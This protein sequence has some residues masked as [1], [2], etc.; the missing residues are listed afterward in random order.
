MLP[1][2]RV[3][4]LPWLLPLD[5]LALSPPPPPSL[6]YSL[7]PPYPFT[8][9]LNRFT[10]RKQNPLLGA[11]ALQD[12]FPAAS[13]LLLTATQQEQVIRKHRQAPQL[14]GS[15]GLLFSVP[16]AE[17]LRAGGGTARE[18]GEMGEGRERLW[19]GE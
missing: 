5:C 12:Q 10:S 19:P 3:Q 13:R 8:W 18:A 11:F 1:L 14:P 17:W 15:C 7:S 4:H 2:M 16:A 9:L 6:T